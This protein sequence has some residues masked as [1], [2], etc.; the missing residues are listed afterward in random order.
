MS[1]LIQTLSTYYRV[2]QITANNALQQAFINRWSN[3]L[4][5]I[6]KVIRLAVSLGF[7]FL[8][9]NQHVSVAGY[10]TDQV[11]VFFLT[12][13]LVDLLSQVIYRGVYIFGQ[14]IHTGN[15]DFLLTKPISPLFRAL[16]GL[17]DINDT[18]FLIPTLGI[19]YY[20]LTTLSLTLQPT[21]IIWYLVLLINSM[22][23]STSM[24]ILV[25]S[26]GVITTQIDSIVWT[27]RDLARL[28]QMPITMYLQ[29]LRWI[30]FFV[31]PVGFMITVPAEVLLGVKPSYSI[32]IT[33]L[34]GVSSFWISWRVWHWSLKKYS[35]ASS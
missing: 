32:L 17:P 15:F 29:P 23:I 8:L 25:I 7:L 18:I 14:L 4:F 24:H 13:Q 1:K 30:L 26:L 12:Y 28:G 35:S 6:G 9:K 11:I 10:T 33:T 19:S 3:L 2:W 5:L 21:D 31:F 34:V 20:L 27:Y 16:T 22:L